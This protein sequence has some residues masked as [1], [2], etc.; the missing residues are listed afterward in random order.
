MEIHVSLSA[1]VPKYT[2]E[3]QEVLMGLIHDKSQIISAFGGDDDL[4][5]LIRKYSEVP[6]KPLYRGIYRQEQSR[7]NEQLEEQGYAR[8]NRY[9]SFSEDKAIAKKFAEVHVV[10][11]LL[12]AS[13]PK[14]KGFNYH[15][16][17][18]DYI[19]SIPLEEAFSG[20]E[21]W[22]DDLIEGVEEEKEWIYP[23]GYKFKVVGTRKEGQ[24]T[25]LT[26]QPL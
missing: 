2:E 17:L 16:R 18:K 14:L 26:I 23:V 24:Y 25:I 13:S 20:D 3:Q 10:L 4:N 6:K 11:E 12:P 15:Q 9:M 1:K 22:R 21:E 8:L 7:I 5:E 19:L